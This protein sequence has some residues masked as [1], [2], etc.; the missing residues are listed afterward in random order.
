MLSGNPAGI[1]TPL[2]VA[3]VPKL[4]KNCNTSKTNFHEEQTI[5]NCMSV[6]LSSTNRS[7]PHDSKSSRSVDAPPPKALDIAGLFGLSTFF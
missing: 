6:L 4:S 2:I 5:W 3:I 1:R 7:A